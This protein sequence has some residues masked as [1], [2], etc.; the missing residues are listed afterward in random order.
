M[1]KTYREENP[2]ARDSILYQAQM[3]N[4]FWATAGQKDN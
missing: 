1:G 4:K 2:C 3:G